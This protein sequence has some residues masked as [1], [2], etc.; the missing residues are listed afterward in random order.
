MAKYI[1]YEDGSRSYVPEVGDFVQCLRGNG[2]SWQ[3]SAD[4][5]GKIVRV[6]PEGSIVA[7][8]DICFAGY[9]R[10][11]DC[12]FTGWRLPVWDVRV[13][14][15]RRVKKMQRIARAKHAAWC[16]WHSW[17]A[18]EKRRNGEKL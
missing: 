13:M 1:K 6:D 3:Y 8:I 18:E 5:W 15:K 4:D 14:A 11:R 2:S 17:L 9:S 12:M 16:R 7:H 10:K